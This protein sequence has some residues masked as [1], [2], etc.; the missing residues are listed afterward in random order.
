MTY[1]PRRPPGS[2]YILRSQRICRLDQT[3]PGRQIP[4]FF[5]TVFHSATE[6]SVFTSNGSSIMPDS[7]MKL[8]F[9]GSPRGPVTSS[10]EKS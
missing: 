2:R 10:R 9:S 1:I 5:C 8:P 6:N 3:S 7:S 4:S